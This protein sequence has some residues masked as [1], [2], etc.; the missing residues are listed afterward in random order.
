MK[1]EMNGKTIWVNYHHLYCFSIV[2]ATGGIAL[3]AKKLGIGSSALSI[4]VRQFESSLETV[5]FD[6]SHRKLI[7]N[8]NG[9]LLLSYAKEIFRLGGEMVEALKDQPVSGRTHLQIGALDTIPKHL[10]LQLVQAALEEGKCS[11]SITEGKSQALLHSLSEHQLDLVLTNS[12]PLSA[13][14]QYFHKRIARL[15][16]WVVGG[17]SYL[18]LK[19][20]F[21]GSLSGQPFILPT[22]DSS[23]RQEISSFFKRNEI[24]PDI[25]AEAQ[26][27]MIQK[28]LAVRGVGITVAPEFAIREYLK[29]K[30]LFLLGPMGNVHEDLYLMSASR[31]IENR[32]ASRLM[33]SFKVK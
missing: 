12:V 26:D 16:L 25:L 21:P 13:S 20:G 1:I 24:S 7:L 14:G 33:K 28:L 15:P 29:E 32:I 6:R 27:V 22:A 19:K 11:V 4:Q 3:A 17:V 30:S 18:H 23:V 2:A 9:R 31:R 5:L 10:T 8:E